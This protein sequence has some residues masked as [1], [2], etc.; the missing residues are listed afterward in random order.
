MRRLILLLFL[1]LLTACTVPAG[2]YS[3]SIHVPAPVVIQPPKPT[4]LPTPTDVSDPTPTSTNTATVAWIDP[5]PGDITPTLETGQGIPSNT[6][7]VIPPSV[8]RV[9]TALNV[10]SSPGLQNNE[11][12]IG[13]I[14]AGRLVE[15][16]WQDGN[17]LISAN[18]LTW[19]YVYEHINGASG[20][21]AAIGWVAD[22]WLEP[23]AG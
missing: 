16:R 19:A 2:T 9:T 20:Q 8:Y 6:P 3:I 1:L 23:F 10:R 15:I 22:N 21:G 12:K 11:N 4:P 13:Q 14:P 5:T 18:G 17:D 7:Y